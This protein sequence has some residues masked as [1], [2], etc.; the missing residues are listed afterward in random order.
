VLLVDQFDLALSGLGTMDRQSLWKQIAQ[1]L[2]QT[3][4]GLIFAIP[5]EAERLLPSGP[6]WDEM[7]ASRRVAGWS[8][9]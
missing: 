8:G 9:S 2:T 1:R 4:H 3:R 6:L 7:L 5:A